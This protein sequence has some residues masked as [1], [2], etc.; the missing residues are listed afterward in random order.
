MKSTITFVISIHLFV[1]LSPL[2]WLPLGRFMWN[3]TVGTFMKVCQDIPILVT[4][5]YFMWRPKYLTLNHR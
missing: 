5:G 3:L 1:G 4:V 2:S